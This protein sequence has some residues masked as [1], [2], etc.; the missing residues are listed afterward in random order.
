MRPAGF[1]REQL[2]R[3]EG[4]QLLAGGG[5]ERVQHAVIGPHVK[6]IGPA[7]I[8][9][10]PEVGAVAVALLARQQPIAEVH[11][12]G[13]LGIGMHDVAQQPRRI[14]FAAAPE[15]CQALGATQPVDTLRTPRIELVA[16]VVVEGGLLHRRECVVVECH[17]FTVGGVDGQDLAI[18]RQHLGKQCFSVP[19]D[20]TGRSVG[21][22]FPR[23]EEAGPVVAAKAHVVQQRIVLQDGR[24]GRSRGGR[25]FRFPHDVGDHPGQFG[26]ELGRVHRRKVGAARVDRRVQQVVVLLDGVRRRVRP[27][28]HAR[29]IDCGKGFGRVDA[30]L[31][32]ESDRVRDH[33]LP[34]GRIARTRGYAV[35]EPRQQV[36]LPVFH[37]DVGQRGRR[38]V[39]ERRSRRVAA[40]QSARTGVAGRAATVLVADPDRILAVPC[41]VGHQHAVAAAALQLTAARLARRRTP[42]APFVASL[43]ILAGRLQGPAQGRGPQSVDTPQPV[44]ESGSMMALERPDTM[45]EHRRRD[46]VEVG[47][48]TLVDASPADTDRFV[49]RQ[50]RLADPGLARFQAIGVIRV[51]VREVL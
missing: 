42:R 50:E 32:A 8:G 48:V 44:V 15:A 27:G 19:D 35:R 28:N 4:E 3:H 36:V 12:A 20:R 2:A 14:G 34:E 26:R 6:H 16:G 41:T 24:T 25:A 46:P 10:R 9:T 21:R 43:E 18:R 33:V 13:E 29:G 17:E 30:T 51:P 38:A 40:T 1:G 49:E 5:I 31:D 39:L 7:P 23:R 37:R 22:D 45:F 47:G 11:F